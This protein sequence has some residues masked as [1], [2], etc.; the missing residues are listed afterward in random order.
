M[1]DYI[2]GGTVFVPIIMISSANLSYS[3]AAGS[4][5][6]GDGRHRCVGMGLVIVMAIDGLSRRLSDD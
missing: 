2:L 5:S 6:R 3:L 1:F 4:E